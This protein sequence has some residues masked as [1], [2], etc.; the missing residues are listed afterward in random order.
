MSARLEIT[1]LG[2]GSSGGVPRLGND[3]GDC[4]PAEPRNR[5]LRCSILVRRLGAGGATTVLVDTGPDMR[6]Q[7]LDADVEDL[8][9]VLYTHAHADHLHGIDDLRMLAIRHRRRVPVYMDEKTSRRAHAAFGYCFATPPGSSYPPIL[10]EVRLTAGVPA[11]IDGA[12]GALSFLPI[13]VNHGEI[14]ALGFRFEDVAYLPDVSEIPEVAVTQF[15]G[16]RLWIVDALRHKPHPSHFCLTDALTW[17]ADLAP[18]RAVLTNMHN[19]MD[20]AALVRD[21]PAGVEPAHDGMI[22]ELPL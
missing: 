15:A 5:R 6:Q 10:D 22:I 9:A 7:L 13:E 2:C 18:R 8:D 1:I 16:L 21:L 17:I 4:D 11:V 12:G 19:D 14:D 20:Y 3:W